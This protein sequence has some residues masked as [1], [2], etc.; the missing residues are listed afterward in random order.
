MR[1]QEESRVASLFRADGVVDPQN[2]L[3]NHPAHAS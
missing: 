1:G 2:L 3:N